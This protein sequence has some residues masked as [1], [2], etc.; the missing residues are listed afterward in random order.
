MSKEKIIN[1][2]NEIFTSLKYYKSPLDYEI[3]SSLLDKSLIIN[4]LDEL[5]KD[6][7]SIDEEE[8]NLMTNNEIFKD[9]IKLYL[10]RNNI[11]TYK[12]ERLSLDDLDINQRI[13]K[14]NI[15]K[16]VKFTD[17][18]IEILLSDLTRQNREVIMNAE[19]NYVFDKTLSIV[20]NEYIF[21]EL[22]ADAIEVLLSSIYRYNKEKHNSFKEYLTYNLETALNRK[23]LSYIHNHVNVDDDT[24]VV[25]KYDEIV[26]DKILNKEKLD[27]IF[28]KT[29]ISSL[30]RDIIEYLYGIKDG[31][32]HSEEEAALEY[33]M[34]KISIMQIKS[35]T[36]SKL[37]NTIKKK[38]K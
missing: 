27:N 31:I 24:I 25:D 21:E 38:S 6:K 14:E 37:H 10:I 26:T 30:E 2:L 12:D 13:S 36:L 15:S 22:L 19:L 35:L 33:K 29:N 16:H 20:N 1:D 32:R 4:D 28:N 34:N 7:K 9:V 11:K 3:A 5:F 18:E 23:Q 8:I 17:E